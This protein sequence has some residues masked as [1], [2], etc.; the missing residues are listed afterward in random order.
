MKQ[1]A[2]EWIESLN[3]EQLTKEQSQEL[4]K[5]LE[6]DLEIAMAQP[7]PQSDWD[8]IQAAKELNKNNPKQTASTFDYK[9]YLQTDAKAKELFSTYLTKKGYTVD[10][11]EEDYGIDIV[12]T[13]NTEESLFELEI[14]SVSFDKESFPHPEVNFLARKK[15]M[16]DKQGD[17]HYIIIS[18]NHQFALTAK[19]SD[20]FKEEN[21]R[22]KYAGKGR[23][24]VDEFYALPID[25]VKFFKL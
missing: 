11:K 23:D 12:A 17:Y 1:T 18:S 9:T 14:S 6:R 5:E 21:Y 10:L 2:K 13:K 24:G 19:A 25:K 20:I 7:K 4:M 16:I 8:R 15:K 22:T 3:E